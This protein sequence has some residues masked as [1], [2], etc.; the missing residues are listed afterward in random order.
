MEAKCVQNLFLGHRDCMVTHVS[1][2]KSQSVKIS[3]NLKSLEGVS[4]KFYSAKI[5]FNRGLG[6]LNALGFF[7]IIYDVMQ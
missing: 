2:M 4:P 3:T 1:K 7:A 6:S 5:S